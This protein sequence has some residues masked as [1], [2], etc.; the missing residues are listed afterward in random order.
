MNTSEAKKA[1]DA[2]VLNGVLPVYKP[3][4]ISSKDIS[5]VITRKFGRLKLGHAGTLDPI[6]EGVLPILFGR[7]TR[8]QDYLHML[9]KV[10]ICELALGFDTDT[11]DI[12]GQALAEKPYEHVTR[13]S[14][15][16]ALK[17]LTGKQLQ[18]PPLYSAVKH[19]GKSLYKYARSA[20]TAEINLNNHAKEIEIKEI[21]LLSFIKG[22]I[23]FEAR[24]S[25][26]TY[27]R[28][29]ARDLAHSLGTCGHMKSLI[30]KESAGFSLEQAVCLNS[31]KDNTFCFK[32]LKQN[33]LSL[34]AVQIPLPRLK[35]ENSQAYEKF[36]FG[37]SIQILNPKVS[38]SL[39]VFKDE[40]KS[41]KDEVSE[42][43]LENP[44][45][46]VCAIAEVKS[47]V[48]PSGIF[49]KMKRSLL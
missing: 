35:I 23:K 28:V 9:D 42:I 37:Q 33:T 13:E 46:I 38:F 16:N 7:A 36:L 32:A 1:E 30:R 39:K 45:G 26:G 11:L 49:V 47:V 40:K 22:I 20:Q 25:K 44:S 27:I 5:R 4:G 29:L 15:K 14:I 10:Y 12:S 34:T 6:A 19:N 8:I 41:Q 2:S 21:K 3:A 43:L 48:S 31:I 18:T 17:L 24:V